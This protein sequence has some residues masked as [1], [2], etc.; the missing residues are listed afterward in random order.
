MRTKLSF[1]AQGSLAGIEEDAAFC[2][3]HGFEGLEYNYWGNFEQLD[4]RTVEAMAAIQERHGIRCVMLG[5]WGWNHLA[6]DPAE[7]A[8]AHEMLDRAIRFA[9]ML[10]ADVF[11][12]GGGTFSENLAE[13]VA[14]FGRV[15]PPFLERI[16]AG[17]MKAAFYASH[18]KSFFDSLGAY[19]AVWESFP[20]V[21]IKYDPANW[22]HHGDDYLAVVRR[23][24]D[25]VG[26]LHIKEHL[27]HEG[28]LA[29]QPPAG[30]GD[31]KWGKV[32][33]FLYEHHYEGPLSIEPHGP[34]WS[35]GDMRRKLLLLSQRAI[36]PYLI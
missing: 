36:A 29:G 32:F 13:N 31:I 15:F 2:V 33:A 20:Q 14:E 24:G 3:A 27:Y 11:T 25:K 35:R 5:L 30:M 21:S 26:H 1:I 23:H 34:I 17:G 6:P 7:R 8:K 10:R 9:G 4:V 12:T 19:E 22:R 16:G 28:G 18:G